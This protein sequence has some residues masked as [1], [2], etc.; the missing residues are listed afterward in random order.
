MKYSCVLQC[1]YIKTASVTNVSKLNHVMRKKRKLLTRFT[2]TLGNKLITFA[3]VPFIIL[4]VFTKALLELYCRRVL[5][6]EKKEQN[7]VVYQIV[8]KPIWL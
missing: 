8:G 1:Q 4:P 3:G 2:P 5:A 7:F 6:R